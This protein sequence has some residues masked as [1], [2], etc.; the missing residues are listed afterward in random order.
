MKVIMPKKKKKSN[1]SKKINII[2][3]IGLDLKENIDDLVYQI[4]IIKNDINK[5]S[6]EAQHTE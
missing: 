3:S 6:K 2:Q 5:L 1:S 4:E